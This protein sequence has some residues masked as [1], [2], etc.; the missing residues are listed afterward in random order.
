[1]KKGPFIASIVLLVIGIV[2]VIIGA[3]LYNPLSLTD[4]VLWCG[5]IVFNVGLIVLVTSF[6]KKPTEESQEKA[7]NT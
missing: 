7:K 3:I 4:Y 6:I 2:M 1:M 5:L